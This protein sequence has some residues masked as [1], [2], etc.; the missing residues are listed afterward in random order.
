MLLDGSPLQTSEPKS[1]FGTEFSL[2]VTCVIVYSAKMEQATISNK[3][4]FPLIQFGN[5]F[6][7]P[8]IT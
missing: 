8:T 3:F 4:F 7:Y 1:T 5:V 6:S 2:T